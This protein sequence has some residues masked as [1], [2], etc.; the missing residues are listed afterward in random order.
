MN[1]LKMALMAALALPSLSAVAE[2]EKS[3]HSIDF[4][5]GLFSQYIFRGLQQT[6]GNPALQGSV[7]YSH[8]SGLYAGT[9]FSTISWARDAYSVSS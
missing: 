8:E 5:I 1:K 9:W 6:N 7:D 3:A 4:N 2:E